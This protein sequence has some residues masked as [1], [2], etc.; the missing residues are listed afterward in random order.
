MKLKTKLILAFLFVSTIPII[1]TSIVLSINSKKAV[2]EQAS[3]LVKQVSKEKLSFIDNYIQSLEKEL[4]IISTNHNIKNEN[5]EYGMKDI[6][7]IA[8]MGEDILA[9]YVAFSD[10]KLFIAPTKVPEGFDATSRDWYKAA[11]S[12]KGKMTVSEPYIDE[13][14]KKLVITISKQ[15]TTNSGKD[16]V[17]GIDLALDDLEVYLKQEKI[18]KSGYTVVARKDG[19]ILLHPDEKYVSEGK[20]LKDLGKWGEELVNGKGIKQEISNESGK[21]YIAGDSRSE[22]LG[23][24]AVSFLPKDECMDSI[25]GSLITTFIIGGILVAIVITGCFV[26]VTRTMREVNSIS[27]IIEEVGSGRLDIDVK[28]DRND[29][30]GI[31]QRSLK[32]LVD[33][34]SG[35]VQNIEGSSH[36]IVESFKSLNNVL[37]NN[38][39]ANEEI[40]TAIDEFAVICENN[41]SSI[42]EV[43]ASIEEILTGYKGMATNINEVKDDS[44][45][46]VNIADIG[47]KSLEESIEAMEEIEKATHGVVSITKEM[48]EHSIK[49]DY[50]LGTITQIASQTNLLA[51][52]AALEAA[53]A[54]E[55]GK[56]FSVVAEEVRNLAEQSSASAN[57]ISFIIEN[58]TESIK[59]VA[60]AA[61]GKILLVENGKYKTN[62]VKENISDIVNAIENIDGLLE[63][64][65]SKTDVQ[66]K[67]IEEIVLAIDSVSTSVE[68]CASLTD[69][70][71]SA[72]NNQESNLND[73]NISVNSLSSTADKLEEAVSTFKLK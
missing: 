60:S 28:V 71:N 33:S 7:S 51:L 15:F 49:I 29:E 57:E 16:A 42:E 10:K 41:C 39:K 5:S 59:K 56:G 68:E 14:S 63:N 65:K 55:A 26:I 17:G 36:E 9:A 21:E 13:I 73:M 23:W 47:R 24:I 12:N 69:N 2:T 43:N 1:I 35:I 52:N 6:Q 11:M 34:L 66:Y 25:D 31:I 38:N 20:N 61:S 4:N 8:G 37:D 62:N 22:K 45:N 44:K 58:I 48:E 54:G 50:I 72:K 27:K 46:A 67:S 19:S 70:I 3:N 30:L 32:S 53:R 40:S 64:I 18:G